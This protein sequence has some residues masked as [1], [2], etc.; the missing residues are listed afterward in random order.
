M[1]RKDG[2]EK[3]GVVYFHGYSVLAMEPVTL[4]GKED[5]LIKC[6][7]VWGH[8]EWNGAWSDQS[9]LWDEHPKIRAKLRLSV[10]EDGIFWIN[11]DDFVDQFCILWYCF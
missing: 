6:R 11:S 7:N 10:K 5:H 2:A 8:F 1:P 9:P 3:Y 4:N